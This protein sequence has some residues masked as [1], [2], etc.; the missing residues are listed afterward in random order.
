M[1]TIPEADDMR[2]LGAA[3]G[4][5]AQPGDLVML[6]GPLGA[7]KTTMT[8]GIAAGLGVKGTVASPTF[9]IAQI[10]H[11]ESMDLVHVDAYRL[12]SVEELDALDLDTTLEESLTVVEWGQGKV[13]VLT[14]DRLELLI[15]RPMGTNFDDE[16]RTIEFVAHGER[17]EELL[18]AVLSDLGG[19]K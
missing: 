10:H 7:G 3:I 15:S 17:G 9:V 16:T 8:Q 6:T 12:G 11:G 18:A 4:R 2:A 5:N 19:A 14:D 1:I 13:E